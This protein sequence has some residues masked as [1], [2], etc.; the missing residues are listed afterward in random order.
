MSIRPNIQIL[1]AGIMSS[2]LTVLECRVG[3][4]LKIKF[5]AVAAPKSGWTS[6]DISLEVARYKASRYQ[7]TGHSWGWDE[8]HP[9]TEF[10]LVCK[11]E[12]T[13]K[14]E[15]FVRKAPHSKAGELRSF[16]I[17]VTP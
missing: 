3:E 6:N 11:K 15:F 12:G 10:N 13:Y 5:D 16:Q 1:K 4:P 9:V 14:V 8:E 17:K 7:S 2:D